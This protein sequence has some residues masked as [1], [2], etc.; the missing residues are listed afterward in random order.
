VK[1]EDR[2]HQRGDNIIR[3]KLKRGI[4]GEL[5]NINIISHGGDKN[6]VD[7]DNQCNI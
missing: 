2:A 6:W 5:P 7:A 3:S 4:E 1:W